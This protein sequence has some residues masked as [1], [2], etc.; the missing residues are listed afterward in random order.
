MA[1]CLRDVVASCHPPL[2]GRLH[3][4]RTSGLMTTLFRL[5]RD[6]DT[7][8]LESLDLKKLTLVLYPCFFLL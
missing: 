7:E 8:V 6:L 5:W 1:G 3:T 2:P 4:Q